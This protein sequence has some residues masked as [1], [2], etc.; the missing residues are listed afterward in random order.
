MG[1]ARPAAAAAAA[2]VVVGAAHLPCLCVAWP[3]TCQAI[4]TKPLNRR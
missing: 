4:M 3:R 2:A 1:I